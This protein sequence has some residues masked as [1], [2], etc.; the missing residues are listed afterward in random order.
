MVQQIYDM[1]LVTEENIFDREAYDYFLLAPNIERRSRAAFLK[2][3]ENLNIDK[4]IIMDYK[5]FHSNISQEQEDL[6]YCDLGTPLS[7]AIREETDMAALR[8]LTKVNIQKKDRIA[9]DITGFSIPNLYRI[10]YFI[11]N[12][13]S[14]SMKK[15]ILMHIT[16]KR[17]KSED[18]HRYKDIVTRVRMKRK[19]WLSFLDLMVV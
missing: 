13:S 19:F 14:I 15:G 4:T 7:T 11:L 2:L 12:R 5:N 17:R 10:M 9:F 16:T 3:K 1:E 8:E 18:V 6:F